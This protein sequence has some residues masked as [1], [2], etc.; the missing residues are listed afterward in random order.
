LKEMENYTHQPCRKK[1][2]LGIR[3]K[4]EKKAYRG[5]RIVRRKKEKKSHHKEDREQ[6]LVSHE[7][8][9][10][11]GN[12]TRRKTNTRWYMEKDESERG[13]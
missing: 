3:T 11:I 12:L 13:P 1:K 9:L 6:G 2:K 5:E 8:L 7:N 4:G 10:K